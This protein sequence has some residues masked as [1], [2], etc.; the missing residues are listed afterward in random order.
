M[1]RV[2]I[3]TAHISAKFHSCSSA[4]FPRTER[5]SVSL[6]AASSQAPASSESVVME[7]FIVPHTLMEG[8]E[9]EIDGDQL[10]SLCQA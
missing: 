6:E 8:G 7:H 10:A 9:K 4:L 2:T 5:L 1:V 3:I